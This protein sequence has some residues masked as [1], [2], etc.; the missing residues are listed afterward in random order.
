M[1]VIYSAIF[2]DETTKNDLK[3]LA[4]DV[5]GSLYENEK[6]HH[7]TL[8]FGSQRTKRVGDYLDFEVIG[9]CKDENAQAFAVFIKDADVE[10]KVPHITVSH[11]DKVTA[12]YSNELFEKSKTYALDKQIKF[13]GRVG[14][15]VRDK[16]E[17]KIVYE[18]V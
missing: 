3:N 4:Q 18:Q 9:Y 13:R 15:F 1:K 2:L 5:F 17:E 11:T 14:Y 10:N 12:K 16:S 7:I 8:S 6:T